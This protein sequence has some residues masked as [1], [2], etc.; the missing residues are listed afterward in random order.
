[1]HRSGAKTRTLKSDRPGS[2]AL[3]LAGCVTLEKSLNLSG[4][5]LLHLQKGTGHNSNDNHT[6][7]TGRG[8]GE[9]ITANLLTNRPMVRAS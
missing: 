8:E 4:L 1:M 9:N 6:G 3:P 2:L 7:H 5:H